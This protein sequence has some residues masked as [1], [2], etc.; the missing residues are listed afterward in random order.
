MKLLVAGDLC[1]SDR[2]LPLFGQERYEEMFAEAAAVIRRADYALVNLEC[3]L[4]EGTEEPIEK[5]GMNLGCT[6]KVI[7]ALK[8]L[9]FHGVTLA[10]ANISS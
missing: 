3:P 6:E 8:Y 5:Q 9:G 10:S 1:P 4:L 7:A 2:M